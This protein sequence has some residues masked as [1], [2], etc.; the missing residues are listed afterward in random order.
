MNCKQQ[1]QDTHHTYSI[2]KLSAQPA[3]SRP[4]IICLM[5]Q[6]HVRS[7][8]CY[9]FRVSCFKMNECI[10]GEQLDKTCLQGH[11]GTTQCWLGHKKW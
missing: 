11:S 4:S 7:F 9:P 3:C 5:E 1:P 10:T 2:I 6:P 8:D